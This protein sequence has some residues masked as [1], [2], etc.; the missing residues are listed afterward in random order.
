MAVSLKQRFKG[1]EAEVVKAV[2]KLGIDSAM[3]LYGAKHR[4]TFIRWLRDNTTE[5]WKSSPLAE[6]KRGE[7]AKWDREHRDT[8][9]DCLEIFGMDWI[10][11]NFHF[12]HDTLE[13]L[14]QFD[15][16]PPWGHDHDKK[17]TRL[18]RVELDVREVL[19]RLREVEHKLDLHSTRL[20]MADTAS[21]EVRLAQNERDEAYSQFTQRVSSQLSGKVQTAFETLLALAINPGENLELPSRIDLSTEGLL[22]QAAGAEVE[23]AVTELVP[24]NRQLEQAGEAG[25]ENEELLRLREMY[26]KAHPLAQTNNREANKSE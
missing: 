14:V 1:K 9:L 5:E 3:A 16:Q 12:T 11:A 25:E 7:K 18:E 8:I 21:R 19:K 20:D 4:K 22:L 17:L 26:L 15:S 10:K 6:M 23:H 2:K 13:R 24:E